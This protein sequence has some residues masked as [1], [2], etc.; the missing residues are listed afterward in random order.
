MSQQTAD[1]KL[2]QLV[3]KES[4]ETLPKPFCQF[5]GLKVNTI[6]EL[7]IH[8]LDQCK[9]IEETENPTKRKK[10]TQKIPKKLEGYEIGKSR[11]TGESDDVDKEEL[12]GNCPKCKLYITEEDNGIVCESC[13]AYWHY[14][15]AGVTQEEVDNLGIEEF[16]CVKHR[17]KNEVMSLIV[18]KANGM[19]GHS[20]MNDETVRRATEEVIT[21][22]FRIH[23]Y[24]L[25][26]KK[27]INKKIK[28][29]DTAC[30]INPKDGGRQFTI[31]VNSVT[32]Q[33]IKEKLADFG[34]Q[35]NISI[36]RPAFDD[37]GKNVDN[38]Y[39][40]VLNGGLTE[41]AVT[42]YHTTNLILLQVK[43][44]KNEK[45]W[46]NKLAD[47]K[48]FV[49]GT[50]EPLV[51][52]I[53]ALPQ[54]GM[55]RKEFLERLLATQEALCSG[56]KDALVNNGC[57]DERKETFIFP[58]IDACDEKSSSLVDQNSRSNLNVDLSSKVSLISS[59][60]NSAQ[61]MN[62]E[63]L[64]NESCDGNQDLKVNDDINTC[65]QEVQPCEGV[66][67]EA[68]DLSIMR[69]ECQNSCGKSEHPTVQC[70][71]NAVNL[72]K[73]VQQTSNVI[74]IQTPPSVN[75]D[76]ACK[77]VTVRRNSIVNTAHSFLNQHV[78]DEEIITLGVEFKNKKFLLS[79]GNI[80]S[81]KG[82]KNE[83]LYRTILK[84]KEKIGILE[85][86]KQETVVPRIE[87]LKIQEVAQEVQD[88]N[89]KLEEMKTK[90][91]KLTEENR[92]LKKERVQMTAD[93]KKLM[94]EIAV[95]EKAIKSKENSVISLHEKV[96]L[97]SASEA[98]LQAKIQLLESTNQI[99]DESIDVS[100]SQIANSIDNRKEIQLLEAKI[101]RE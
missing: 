92:D 10:R 51:H 82:I 96:V 67:D 78:F 43:G 48:M 84:L 18:S 50:M 62:G 42:C 72:D 26:E 21:C 44:R 40:V 8:Q 17:M 1:D 80:I 23:S 57:N 69:S 101:R 47:L 46:D 31:N 77:E 100:E 2:M 34:E 14:H 28:N 66:Y 15:C 73:G 68:Q 94:D 95:K 71:Q 38:Q 5:C 16:L 27:A 7:H 90:I 86:E 85:A 56:N 58:K 99:L 91:K 6:D 83:P 98:R 39:V 35:L 88:K 79:L 75:M 29:I 45:G 89:T 63:K 65:L 64:Q 37:T 81:G 25:N 20:V 12:S 87:A 32:Y 59:E 3:I 55:I 70:V 24:S 53:Q 54:Y 36:K 61:M 30:V 60:T 74:A 4:L 22:Q 93:R 9:V 52:M 13:K 33:I 97:L 11:R 76:Q 49:K 19:E 41:V